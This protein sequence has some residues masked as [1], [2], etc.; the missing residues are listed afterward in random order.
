VLAQLGE[1][2]INSFDHEPF[3]GCA[4][5]A[6]CVNTGLQS[7]GQVDAETTSK[8]GQSSGD[9]AVCGKKL[10]CALFGG[11]EV[12]TAADVQWVRINAS[13]L[14]SHLATC[15]LPLISCMRS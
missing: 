11:D 1:N 5:D 3:H 2:R 7:Y 14:S 10:C 15:K 6:Q 9:L 8:Y 13:H 12:Q 4:V